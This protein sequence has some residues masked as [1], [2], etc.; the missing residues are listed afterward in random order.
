MKTNQLFIKALAFSILGSVFMSCQKDEAAP[1]VTIKAE[2]VKD[3]AADPGVISGTAQP[4]LTGKYTFFSFQNGILASS[5]SA[6]TKWD[7]AFRGTIILT[8]GGT[9]GPGMG[10]AIVRD[11]LFTDIK[12]APTTGFVQDSKTSFAITAS[13]GKGWYNYNGAT[14]IISPIAGKVIIVKTADGKYAKMEI[15]SYYKGAPATPDANSVG[16]YYTFRFVYQGNGMTKF[17]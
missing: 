14:N 7:L 3:L 5:D 6:T 10:G 13:S 8:N 15:L 9:S 12:E 17:E 2:T 11:A 1:V 16:R 4:V